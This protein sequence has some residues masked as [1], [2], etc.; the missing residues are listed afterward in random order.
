M[1]FEDRKDIEL[2]FKGFKIHVIRIYLKN[3]F[4]LNKILSILAH[5]YKRLLSK[6][7]FNSSLRASALPFQLE[8][9]S[10]KLHWTF[11]VYR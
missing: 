9:S 6:F 7:V 10:L 1:L 5:S 3:L 11:R 2:L 4:L 8:I